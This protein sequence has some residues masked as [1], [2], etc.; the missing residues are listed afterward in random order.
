MH[1]PQ[2]KS[3]ALSRLGYGAA[4]RALMIS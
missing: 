4:L 3:E 1:K 2:P